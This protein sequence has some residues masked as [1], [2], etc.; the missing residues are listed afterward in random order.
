MTERIDFDGSILKD[1]PRINMSRRGIIK[2]LACGSVLPILSSCATNPETGRNQLLLFGEGQIAEM[3]STAWTDMKAQTPQT[4]D[5]GLQRRVNTIWGRIANASGRGDQQWDVAVFD[6]DDVN[7]F[8]MPGNKVG[9]YR[10]IAEFTDNDDQLSSVLG[11]EVGH[12]VGKHAAERM[13]VST[14]AQVGL[15]AG[16]I[17]IASSEELSQ[18]GGQIAALGGAALQFGVILPYSRNHELEADKLGVDYMHTA[19]YDV[20]ESVRLWEK[21]DANSAGQRPPEFMSTHPDPSRRANDLRN[22]INARGYALI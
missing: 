20:K 5:S 17:A 3:A 11:H 10:G 14:V 8:V 18:Y 6:T 22:Y 9:V 12:V 21:M 16:Q 4:G 19:G 15:V 2:G 13:S 7:A 1:A